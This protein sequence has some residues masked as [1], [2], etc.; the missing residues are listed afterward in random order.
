MSNKK[1][2]YLKQSSILFEFIKRLIEADG[3]IVF[4]D[5]TYNNTQIADMCRC[6]QESCATVY[7]KNTKEWDEKLLGSNIMNTNH[8]M[9]I[10]RFYDGGVFDFEAIEYSKYP[11][12]DEIKRVFSGDFSLPSKAELEELDIYFKNLE[13]E[14]IDTIV[15]D[16]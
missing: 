9:V 8:G 11:Y 1:P 3:D 4:S 15:I 2:I 10:T 5:D 12:R 6:G 7:L 14:E 13:Y 16:T